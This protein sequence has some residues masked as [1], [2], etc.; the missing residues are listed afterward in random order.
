M[1]AAVCSAWGEVESLEVRDMPAPEPGEGEVAIRVAAAG[2]NFADAI[3][4]AGNYQTRPEHP[5]A[6]GLEVAGEVTAV[7][8]GCERLVLGDRV[9][10]ILWWG[11]YA[12]TAIARETE[13]FLVP[14]G[15]TD[16]EAAAFPTAWVS[17]HVAIRWQAD[18]R[19]GETMLV[20]GAAGGVGLAAVECGKA[21]GARVIAAASSPE[22]LALAARHGAD[23]G[24]DYSVE[25]VKARVAELTDGRGVDVVY[26]P[27]GGPLFDEALSSLAW[28]GRILL[29]G[30]VAGVPRIP[31]NRLLVKHRS[32]M[33]SSMR[34]FRRERPD[35]LLRSMEELAA[36]YS[37]GKVVPRVTETWGLEDVPKAIRR[38]TERQATGKVVVTL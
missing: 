29:I 20:L 22:R 33:G 23:D 1:R 12:E 18:L 11:G 3:M 30:F 28:G 24:I 8:P 6:P 9:M 10:A 14:E 17:S 37:E 26:D 32:A 31:A 16:T 2:V 27:V 36:W 13:A 35:L 15:M 5:F 25:S 38:L 4:I 19:P 21:L 34:Y 7:G